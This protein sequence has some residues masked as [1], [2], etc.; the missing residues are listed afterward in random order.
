M[1]KRTCDNVTTTLSKHR[2]IQSTVCPSHPFVCTSHQ[3]HIGAVKTVAFSPTSLLD[4]SISK[5]M[6]LASGSADRT[7]RL[8]SSEPLTS[9]SGPANSSDDHCV[10]ELENP[11]LQ[12]GG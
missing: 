12:A 7:V 8:W 2:F 6:W 10:Y 4:D 9:S 5:G 11:T 3:G 1:Q